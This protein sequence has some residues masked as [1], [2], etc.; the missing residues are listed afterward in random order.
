MFNLYEN[1]F[2]IADFDFIPTLNPQI[3]S[4]GL[5]KKNLYYNSA[6]INSNSFQ[7]HIF[8]LENNNWD[9]YYFT[10]TIDSDII[11]DETLISKLYGY[12]FFGITM[13]LS[14][15]IIKK[16]QNWNQKKIIKNAL[17]ILQEEEEDQ[18]EN[19]KIKND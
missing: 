17:K 14:Y 2:K 15:Y 10:R 7:L 5:W 8:N 12:I 11:S 19:K 3:T 13:A 9:F 18:K 4:K 16:I 1:N 6:I